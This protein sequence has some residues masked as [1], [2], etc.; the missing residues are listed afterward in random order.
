MYM[1][2]CLPPLTAR[3]SEYLL[4]KS[5]VVGRGRGESTFHVFYWLL[6][7]LSPEERALYS[8][9]DKASFRYW[10]ISNGHGGLF[11]SMFMFWTVIAWNESQSKY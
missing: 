3:F 5:R 2:L 7:G 4:E 6:A 8:I 1:T 9:P 10:Q 11:C